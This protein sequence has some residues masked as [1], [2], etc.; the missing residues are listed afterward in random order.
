M[1]ALL[2][3]PTGERRAEIADAALRLAGER[4]L[5]VLTAQALADAVGLTA[6][7][8]FRHFPSCDAILIEAVRRA[9][10]R[11][12]ATFPP[13]KAAP[14]ERLFGLLRA[15]VTLLR[16]DPGV[17][18]LLR[19][20]EAVLALPVPAVD[21]LR[22]LVARSRAYLRDALADAQADGTVRR[23]LPAEALVPVVTGTLHALAG[24]PGVHRLAVPARPD[25]L[26][27]ALATLRTLLA[28]AAP[29]RP[30]SG[31]RA[32]EPSAP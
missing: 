16:R 25:D 17:A 7:A 5:T 10:E 21:Q 29:A 9:A 24:P 15:R 27:P 18:W 31:A 26:E 13:A 23:D 20:D 6:G 30:R 32:G 8:I 12:D 3:K 11:V 14:V 28:P 4:G 1:R 2:R 19:S 22:D